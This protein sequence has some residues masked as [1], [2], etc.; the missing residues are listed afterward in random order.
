MRFE[1]MLLR[2]RRGRTPKTKGGAAVAFAPLRVYVSLIFLL[3][4]FAAPA[5]A[6]NPQTAAQQ[7]AQQESDAAFG[8]ALLAAHP[9]W[10]TRASAGGAAPARVANPRAQRA[11]SIMGF[12]PLEVAELVARACPRVVLMR[13]DSATLPELVRECD[14]QLEHRDAPERACDPDLDGLCVK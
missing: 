7:A 12:A 5:S 13:V 10:D 11:V 14:R 3:L 8:E 4:I 2:D 9:E 6:A 1:S